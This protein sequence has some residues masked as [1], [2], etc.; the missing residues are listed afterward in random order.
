MLFHVSGMNEVEYGILI[1]YVHPQKGINSPTG[2]GG[3]L[4]PVC[5]YCLCERNLSLVVS[6]L[7]VSYTPEWYMGCNK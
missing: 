4:P 6:T 5:I 7:Y 1:E 2:G 3:D